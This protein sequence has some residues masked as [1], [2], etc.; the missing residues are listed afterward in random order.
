ML[1]YRSSLESWEGPFKFINIYGETVI[2]Q[3]PRER[4]VFKSSWVRPFDS[5]TLKDNNNPDKAVVLNNVI[6]SPE[7]EAV[8]KISASLIIKN[9]MRN[10]MKSIILA[11]NGTPTKQNN[12]QNQ[13]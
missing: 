3:L 7:P 1:V 11:T 4:K 8:Y 9:R 12:S 2:I 10:Q 5:S 6:P 13:D